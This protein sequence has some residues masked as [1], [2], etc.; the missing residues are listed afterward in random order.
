MTALRSSWPISPPPADPATQV[1]TCG[2]WKVTSGA[3]KTSGK[4]LHGKDKASEKSQ[5]WVAVLRQ[6]FGVRNLTETGPFHLRAIR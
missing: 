2:N 6:L 5:V 1:S 4:F 3:C